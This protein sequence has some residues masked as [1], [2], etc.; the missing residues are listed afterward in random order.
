MIERV[1]SAV[2]LPLVF[3]EPMV[4]MFGSHTGIDPIT[5]IITHASGKNGL[6]CQSTPVPPPMQSLVEIALCQEARHTEIHQSESFLF[7]FP[8][9]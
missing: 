3:K 1:T 4:D 2:F 6:S 7:I 5:S 9:E 8:E